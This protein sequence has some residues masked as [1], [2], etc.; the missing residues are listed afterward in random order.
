MTGKL[1]GTRRHRG[2]LDGEQISLKPL[3]FHLVPDLQL[4]TLA[5]KQRTVETRY[6][7]PT[8]R[9]VIYGLSTVADGL[10]RKASQSDPSAVRDKCY[11]PLA[12]MFLI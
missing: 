11:L 5:R 3:K 10:L 9:R 7:A 2:M 12:V 1:P 4:A 8:V 6:R